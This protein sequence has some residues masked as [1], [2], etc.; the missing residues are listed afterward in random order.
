MSVSLIVHSG[1]SCD[2]KPKPISEKT[3]GLIVMDG[4]NLEDAPSTH[5]SESVVTI[6]LLRFNIVVTKLCFDDI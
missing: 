2:G 5:Q 6:S 1:D 4:D 3:K